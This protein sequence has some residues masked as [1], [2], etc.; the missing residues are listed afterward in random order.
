MD[1]SITVH[2]KNKLDNFELLFTTVYGPLSFSDRA[3][4]LAELRAISTLGPS[5]WLVCGD[6]NLIRSR[7][8]K[9]GVSF[10]FS[11]SNRFNVLIADLHLVEQ[12]L[13]DRKFTW[14]RS[15]SSTSK[16]L[17]DRFFC[18]NDWLADYP[19]SIVLS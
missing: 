14:S 17:L 15:I 2:L 18:T 3:S 13:L 6:F 16:A 11:L 8:E 12:P 4:F 9:Q 1:F 7:A 10:N 5:A 19:N